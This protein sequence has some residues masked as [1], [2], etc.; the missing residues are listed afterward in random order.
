MC[1]SSQGLL[2]SS[3]CYLRQIW[4]ALDPRRS[5]VWYGS[6]RHVACLAV[7]AHQRHT[8]HPDHWKRARRWV[9]SSCGCVDQSQGHKHALRRHWWILARADLPGASCQ[10][11]SCPGSSQ[12]HPRGEAGTQCGGYGR[13]ARAV[14]EASC[15]AIASCW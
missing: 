2:S 9:C 3:A 14:V 15:L 11:S 12:S 13:E 1:P 8:R 10:L 5:D 4:G 7:I 6:Y